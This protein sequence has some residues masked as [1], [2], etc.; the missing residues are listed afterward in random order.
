MKKCCMWIEDDIKVVTEF[1]CLLRHPVQRKNYGLKKTT[2][3][4]V[5]A[6]TRK[7]APFLN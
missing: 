7:G 2:A 1:P 5:K 4:A 3:K 6:V